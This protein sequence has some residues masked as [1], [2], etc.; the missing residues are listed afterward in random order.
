VRIDA[1]GVLLAQADDGAFTTYGLELDV[2]PYT[3][4]RGRTLLTA[5]LSPL[6]DVRAALLRPTLLEDF[7]SGRPLPTAD[8]TLP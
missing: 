6:A 1:A 3:V 5:P 8:T 2:A 7:M 4:R